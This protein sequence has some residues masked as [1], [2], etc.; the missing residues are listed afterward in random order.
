MRRKRR[1]RE[2][3]SEDGDE[4]DDITSAESES[5]EED[6]G[7]TGTRRLRTGSSSGRGRLHPQL[8]SAPP[9]QP[10]HPVFLPAS[11]DSAA[12]AAHPRVHDVQSHSGQ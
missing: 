8:L 7:S 6:E 12:T 4:E 3:E 2:E 10:H 5:S 9:H 1:R 11:G